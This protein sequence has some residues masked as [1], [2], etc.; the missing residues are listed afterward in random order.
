MDVAY[1]KACSS[2][3]MPSLLASALSWLILSTAIQG[4]QRTGETWC[5]M[6]EIKST[7]TPQ[8]RQA[9]RQYLQDTGNPSNVCVKKYVFLQYSQHWT[10]ETNPSPSSSI[11]LNMLSRSE[12]DMPCACDHHKSRSHI[13]LYVCAISLGNC[14]MKNSAYTN[15]MASHSLNHAACSLVK[16]PLKTTASPDFS[17]WMWQP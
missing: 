4:R 3:S 9:Y 7:A 13:C 10:K 14:T 16:T 15:T 11:W 1:S 8:H 17:E 12:L 2:H 6:S 5:F